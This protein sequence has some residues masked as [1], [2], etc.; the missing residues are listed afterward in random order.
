ME[1]TRPPSAGRVATAGQGMEMSSA[2][3]APRH[4]GRG[5]LAD[6]S[7]DRALRP[8]H[9]GRGL[10]HREQRDGQAQQQAGD[11]RDGGHRPG[12]PLR[13]LFTV[14]GHEARS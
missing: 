12:D 11:A 10:A 7:V 13:S 9:G 5:D 14:V 2:R 8:Q 3:G 1:T 4:Q 6:V